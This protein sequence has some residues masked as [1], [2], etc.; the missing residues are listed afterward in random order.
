[1]LNSMLPALLVSWG[2]TVLLFRWLQRVDSNWFRFLLRILIFFA[3]FLIGIIGSFSVFFLLL[4]AMSGL[5][6][7]EFLNAPSGAGQQIT[8]WARL[9][10][11]GAILGALIGQFRK[12]RRD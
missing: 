4:W 11:S 12:W 7:S 3:A 5:P 8:S 6:L 9:G 2:T 10:P 1:M